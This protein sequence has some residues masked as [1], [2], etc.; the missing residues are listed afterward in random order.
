MG[1]N[2]SRLVF[3]KT[4]SN[5]TTFKRFLLE[6]VEVEYKFSF[7]KVPVT[8]VARFIDS[9]EVKAGKQIYIGAIESSLDAAAVRIEQSF[10]PSRIV[11]VLVS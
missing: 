2:R 1:F 4:T 7:I 10:S 9:L 3:R 5:Y 6:I 11:R 8:S